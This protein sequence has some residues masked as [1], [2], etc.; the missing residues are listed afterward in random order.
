VSDSKLKEQLPALLKA[1][2]SRGDA[3]GD[4]FAKLLPDFGA[5]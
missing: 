1:A 5:P 3:G 2:R 4:F